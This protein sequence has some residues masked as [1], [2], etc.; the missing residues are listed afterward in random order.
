MASEIQNLIHRFPNLKFLKDN[1]ES[2]VQSVMDTYKSGGKILV[3]GNGGSSADADHIVA[4]LMKSYAKSRPL[5][6]D[7][8]NKLNGIAKDRGPIL[9]SHLEQG[10]PAISL[11]SATALNTAISND[12]GAD[13]IF[14]QQVIS[15][16]YKGD[17]LIGISTSGNSQNV[18]DALIA[19]KAK[20]LICI[21][22]TGK[23]GGNMKDYCDILI[24]V[25]ESKTALIQELHLPIY[26]TI[27]DLIEQKLFQ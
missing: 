25:P 3:C 27:C 22:F 14:A 24:N 11:S 17:I 15:Y 1:I 20:N 12:I 16:G 21:G 19:A 26:H 7:L 5:T 6:D 10:I 9:A 4:E 2:I 18:I 8:K 13:F 23:E